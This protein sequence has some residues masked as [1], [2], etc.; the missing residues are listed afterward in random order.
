MSSSGSFVAR[1]LI[2]MMAAGAALLAG[3]LVLAADDPPAIE[4]PAVARHVAAAKVAA[5]TQWEGLWNVLCAQPVTQSAPPTPGSTPSPPPAAPDKSSW[6]APPV[7]VFDN[8][9]YVGM[10]EYSAWALT[11]SAGIILIDTLYD[12][13]V[14]AEVIDGLRQLGLDPRSIKYAIISHGHRDHSGGARYLQDTLGT[15]IVASAADWDLLDASTDAHPRR[16]MVATDGMTLTLGD[17]SLRLYITPGHTLGTLSMVLPLRD[18]GASHVAVTW[19]GTAFNWLKNRDGYITP[20]R[21]DRFWFQHYITSAERFGSIAARAKADVLLSNH[22]IFDGSKTKLPLLATR[23]AEQPN[24]Y[25][26]GPASVGAY[27]TV[28]RECA[29]AGLARLPR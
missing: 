6:Y 27:L 16:D 26:I 22:T 2:H 4:P 11:T 9:Y 3:G 15:R 29:R 8:L 23:G 14:E 18:C 13:S 28:A 12:Y 21:P 7:K 5:G 1:W 25:V 10:T 20:E 19:G 24:P 17:T